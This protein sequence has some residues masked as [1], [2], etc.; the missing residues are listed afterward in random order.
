M[1]P[2]WQAVMRMPRARQVQW[3]DTL[4]R[5]SRKADFDPAWKAALQAVGR[6]PSLRHETLRHI[7]DTYGRKLIATLF[8][9]K[10]LSPAVPVRNFRALAAL[11]D[12]C[13]QQGGLGKAETQIRSRVLAEQPKTDLDLVRIAVTE[14]GLKAN[15]EWRADAISRRLCILD[16]EPVKVSH[17]GKTAQRDNR[18]L[19]LVRNAPVNQLE[20]YLI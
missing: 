15:P 19:Y 4:S 12:V 17:D 11:F 8:W 6:V 14:R 9:L 1:W 7:Y 18:N 2:Q 10:G 16:R 20:K 5:G 13:V 3:A